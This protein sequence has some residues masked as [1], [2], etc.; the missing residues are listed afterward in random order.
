MSNEESVILMACL[1]DPQHGYDIYRQIIADTNGRVYIRPA[2]TYR[3][4]VSLAQKGLLE[5]IKDSDPRRKC[6]KITRKGK[7]LLE[8]QANLYHILYREIIERLRI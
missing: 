8:Y 1:K 3:L 7:E 2:K 4:L 5:E 6:Y